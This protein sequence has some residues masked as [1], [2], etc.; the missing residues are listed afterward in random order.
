MP[1]NLR[2]KLMN[3]CLRLVVPVLGNPIPIT[4][5][6]VVFV[7]KVCRFDI[8]TAQCRYSL[9]AYASIR[10]LQKD[11]WMFLYYLSQETHELM[12]GVEPPTP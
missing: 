9:L 5:M 3:A 7:V 10:A 8:G 1:P 4:F 11:Q 12:G 2:P 6:L